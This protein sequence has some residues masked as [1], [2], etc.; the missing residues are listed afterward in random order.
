MLK[1]T[2]SKLKNHLKLCLQSTD[3]FNYKFLFQI[4][5]FDMFHNGYP[6]FHNGY[7]MFHNGYPMFHNGYP[8]FHNGY[9]C[10]F[11]K[12]YFPE[13]SLDPSP[14]ESKPGAQTFF[15]QVP[16]LLRVWSD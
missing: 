14:V 6:L 12:T 13:Q 2:I 3:P 1:I 16:I 10:N 4:S 9:P 8:M 15:E 11:Q 7:P 5:F